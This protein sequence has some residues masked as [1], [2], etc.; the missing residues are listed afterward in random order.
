MLLVR[1]DDAENWL[2][3]KKKNKYLIEKWSIET[4][5]FQVY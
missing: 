1:N 3:N 5:N 4:K 2:N